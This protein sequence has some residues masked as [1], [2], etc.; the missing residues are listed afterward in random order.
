MAYQVWGTSLSFHC[1]R[2]VLRGYIV[3]WGYFFISFA[4][5]ECPQWDMRPSPTPQTLAH[6][7]NT[8]TPRQLVNR[9]GKHTDKH[10]RPHLNQ[11]ISK[12]MALPTWKPAQQ[13]TFWTHAVMHTQ[14]L[15]LSLSPNLKPTSTI[16]ITQLEVQ[17]TLPSLPYSADPKHL[18][19]RNHVPDRC[20]IQATQIFYS[21]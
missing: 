4:W 18:G 2:V 17:L 11:I 1:G 10:S 19:K 12:S 3:G 20:R 6:L 21:H 8:R 13:M 7:D 15:T 16:C 14:W 5:K 9:L